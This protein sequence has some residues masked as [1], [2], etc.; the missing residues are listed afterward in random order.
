M[1]R[2]TRKIPYEAKK[3]SFRLVA[4]LALPWHPNNP[5][6]TLNMLFQEDSLARH[7]AAWEEKRINYGHWAVLIQPFMTRSSMGGKALVQEKLL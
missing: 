4:L 2:K 7:S 1:A 5:L 3:S 6:M